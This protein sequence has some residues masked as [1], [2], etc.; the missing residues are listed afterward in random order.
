MI[1]LIKTQISNHPLI[2]TNSSGGEIKRFVQFTGYS[3]FDLTISHV[4]LKFLVTLES[5]EGNVI[6]TPTYLEY[7][8]HTDVWFNAQGEVVASDS[9]DAVITEYDY[10]IGQMINVAV[11]DGQLIQL[12]I[13]NLDVNFQYFNQI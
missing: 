1:H 12:G 2:T 4:V 6:A 13:L 7:K 9:P 11:P 3:G 8:L 5:P 10:W